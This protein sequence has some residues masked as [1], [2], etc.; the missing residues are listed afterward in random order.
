[1]GSGGIGSLSDSAFTRTLSASSAAGEPWA[2]VAFLLGLSSLTHV[3]DSTVN[4]WH[5]FE[6]Q[7]LL[8][9]GAFRPCFIFSQ[10]KK[11]PNSGLLSRHDLDQSLEIPA[12]DISKTSYFRGTWNMS[13]Y[14]SVNFKGLFS[15]ILHNYMLH[16]YFQVWNWN[17]HNRTIWSYK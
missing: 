11:R 10:S 15:Y 6:R 9:N 3:L 4:I 8:A 2:K 12:K 16:F 13:Q 1:M 17:K 7:R 14:G 5:T